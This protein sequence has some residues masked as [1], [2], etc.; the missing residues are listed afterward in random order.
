MSKC[1]GAKKLVS[2][3]RD[4][5]RMTPPQKKFPPHLK[6]PWWRAAISP[7]WFF[8]RQSLVSVPHVVT[9]GL[10]WIRAL[11]KWVFFPHTVVQNIRS[12]P[13]LATSYTLNCYVFFAEEPSK[14]KAI[15]QNRSSN[16]ASVQIV[17]TPYTMSLLTCVCVDYSNHHRVAKTHKMHYLCR[18]LSAK[19]QY[20]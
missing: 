2:W 5:S 4:G 10:F 16:L 19:E 9:L 18:S 15:F 14:N 11:Q 8:C 3:F 7:R 17:A 20:N 12:V 1:G 6:L 13:H